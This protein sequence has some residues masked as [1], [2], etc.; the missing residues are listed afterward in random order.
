MR[1]RRLAAAGAAA[2]LLPFAACSDGESN[3]D[4]AEPTSSA[5]PSPS[6]TASAGPTLPPEAQGD[7]EAAAKAFVEFYFELISEAMVT[8]DTS[9]IPQ[10]STADCQTC[11][12]VPSRIRN[13]YDKGGRFETRGWIIKKLAP[14]PLEDPDGKAFI[15]S[16]RET[17][18]RLLNENDELVET[19][20][21]TLHAM[22]IRLVHG[23]PAWRVAQ[24]DFIR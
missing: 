16:V 17:E 5:A 6:E 10:Y 22:R 12:S 21:P 20:K 15:L 24:L 7:D 13:V 2:L 23:G 3:A 9:A 18:R 14:L 1:V 11:K 4:P 8:G 19:V